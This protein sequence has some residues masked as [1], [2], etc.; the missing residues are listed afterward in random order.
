ML[1]VNPLLEFLENIGVLHDLTV[2]VNRIRAL[3]ANQLTDLVDEAALIT[4]AEQLEPT[5][6]TMTHAASLSLGGSAERC[7]SLSCRLKN[8]DQLIQFAAFYSDRVFID[9]FF[10][11]HRRSVKQEDMS[12][13]QFALFNDL[14]VLV[15][16]RPL[17]EVGLIVP[18]SIGGGL[19]GKCVHCW[20]KDAFGV[21][22]Y[23]LNENSRN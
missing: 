22:D 21:A 10:T 19:G 2:D 4:S 1:E 15:R 3:T 5:V 8:V 6:G 12:E 16:L 11:Q 13:R 7:T 23:A 14:K 9:N 18:V 17:I 20:A